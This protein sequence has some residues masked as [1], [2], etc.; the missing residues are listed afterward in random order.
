METNEKSENRN[1]KKDNKEKEANNLDLNQDFQ[2]EPIN[3]KVKKI[4]EHKDSDIINEKEKIGEDK[5]IK[6]DGQEE[7]AEEADEED[8]HAKLGLEGSEDDEDTD[9]EFEE[10][11]QGNFYIFFL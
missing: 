10:F 6:L 1:Y 3:K 9:Q 4:K 8:N 7:E 5:Q 2:I 11:L